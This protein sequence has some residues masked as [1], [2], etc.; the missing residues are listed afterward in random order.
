MS[1]DRG[2]TVTGGFTTDPDQLGSLEGQ[3]YVVVRPTA[4][5]A[6]FYTMVQSSVRLALPPGVTFPNTGHAT[7]R[8]SYEPQ[9][10]RELKLS[11]HQTPPSIFGSM[12]SMGFRLFSRLLSHDLLVPNPDT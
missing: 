1:R 4:D 2:L 12:R 7:L 6:D 9:R 10:V 3:Q 5:V 8:G 11:V